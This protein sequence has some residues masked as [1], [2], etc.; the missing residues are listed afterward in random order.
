[1]LDG[2]VVSE[3]RNFSCAEK[4]VRT[5]ILSDRGSRAFSPARETVAKDL[6]FFE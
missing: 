5:V 4:K 2:R 6:G 1:M 3:G